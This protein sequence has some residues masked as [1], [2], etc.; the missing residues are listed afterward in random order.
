MK[1]A[2][3][4]AAAAA[5]VGPAAPALATTPTP[6]TTAPTAATAGPQLVARWTFDAGA[7]NGRVADTS[8]RGPAL[9][10]RV[11]DQGVVRYETGTPSG[12]HVAFPAACAGTARTCPRALFETSSVANLNPGTRLFR[13]SARVQLTKAQITG[14]ANVM[15]KGVAN[16]TS[17]WKMQ[18]GK[19]NGRAQ[20][21]VVGTGS[22][23]VYI[24]RSSAPVADGRWHKVLCQ[25]S[26]TTLSVWIDNQLG[27]QTTIPAN[28][29]ISNNLPLR[30]GGPNFNTRTD[31]Y[32]GRLDDVYAEL[33]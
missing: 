26:G 11:A 5:L 21:V 3:A 16:T 2:L 22:S 24:A 32:H 33:G 13:W 23:Q 31:M 20:C 6:P 25:R 9:D 14:S 15:Q 28:L 10:T 29:A 12:R 1:L 8:G 7:V 27:G 18:V 19:T 17:Q 4:L 30:V